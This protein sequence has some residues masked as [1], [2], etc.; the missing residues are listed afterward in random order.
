MT[1]DENPK[2]PMHPKPS[3]DYQI[4]VLPF[5]RQPPP[6][7]CMDLVCSGDD[8]MLCKSR[9][10][11]ESAARDMLFRGFPE[12][13][14]DDVLTTSHLQDPPTDPQTEVMKRLMPIDPNWKGA[15]DPATNPYCQC[16]CNCPTSEEEAKERGYI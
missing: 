9:K 14:D 3:P 12:V 7:A 11:R 8:C 5:L 13:R 15:D 1:S 6:M 10:N 4:D 2:I 16:A